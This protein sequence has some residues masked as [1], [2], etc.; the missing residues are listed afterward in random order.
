[1]K[2][3]KKAREIKMNIARAGR[4]VSD[5]NV[6]R[7]SVIEMRRFPDTS[8]FP[9]AEKFLLIS[10][11][12]PHRHPFKF[13]HKSNPQDISSE[14]TTTFKK[15]LN[16]MLVVKKFCGDLRSRKLLLL[17]RKK[18]F[19]RNSRHTHRVFALENRHHQILIL[20]LLQLSF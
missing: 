16:L 14:N 1:L 9:S 5:V 2:H 7:K 8:N 12:F 11:L 18:T 6:D 3:H 15:S 19:S 17:S 13:V 4:F 20:H 10:I